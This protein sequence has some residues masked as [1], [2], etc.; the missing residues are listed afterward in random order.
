[1]IGLS[2]GLMFG[3]AVG[4]PNESSKIDDPAFEADTGLGLGSGG[5]LWIGGALHDAFAVGI[6]QTG[7]AISGNSLRGQGGAFVLRLVGYP[8][9]A[10]GGIGENLGVSANFGAGSFTLKQADAEGDETAAEGGVMSFLGGGVFYEAF[11]W[12]PVAMGPCVEYLYLYSPSLD[13]HAGGLFWRS[14]FYGGP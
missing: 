12:G 14:V 7:G 6:G 4:F 3:N 13:G 9:F 5:T 1:M 10:A 2:G 8:A 11:R